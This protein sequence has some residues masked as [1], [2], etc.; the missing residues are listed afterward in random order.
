MNMLTPIADFGNYLFFSLLVGHIVLQ[1]VPESKKPNIQLP[2]SLLLICSLGIIILTFVPVMN[3]ILYFANSVGFASAVTSV[4]TSSKIGLVWLFI[5]VFALFL[6]LTI[7]L[8]RS[9]YIQ[10][11]W[12]LLMMIA[13]GYSS[14]VSTQ[15]FIVGIF[16]HTTHFLMVTI[17]VG[18]LLHA[19]W[20]S[21]DKQ[22]WSDFLQ[23]F[24]PLAIVCLVNIFT[25]GF[26]IMF[27]I[28]KPTDYLNG[29]ATP[30]GRMLLLKHISIVPIIVFAIINGIL[31][32]KVSA[33]TH[34]EPRTWLKVESII[35]FVIFYFTAVL[36]TLAPPSERVYSSQTATMAPTWIDWLL[37]KN[38]LIPIEIKFAPTLLSVLLMTAA[39]LF[40]LLIISSFRRLNPV[41]ATLFAAC[42][43][44][45]LYLG[46]M[47]SSVLYPLG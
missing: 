36:G 33:S 37:A 30:Y 39:L 28:E 19:S 5:T 23:W 32:K 15:S 41:F 1:F 43:I 47:F 34:Y 46:L 21:K 2:K 42:F 13:I 38:I 22:H 14:H 26:V 3:I 6:W 44:L 12:I 29:W 20:F 4:L 11:I 16:S 25:T 10:A 31:S 27:T 7:Y 18:V 24:S 35:L 8:E 17:W 40:L 45:T 9:K